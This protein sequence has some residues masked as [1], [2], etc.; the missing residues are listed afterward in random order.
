VGFSL[1]GDLAGS[2]EALRRG[3]ARSGT[4]P[5]PAVPSLGLDGVRCEPGPATAG[6]CQVGARRERRLKRVFRALTS[7][8]MLGLHLLAV[9]ATTAAVLL[10]LWQLHAWQAHRDLQAHDLAG[11]P[12]KPLVE[13][14][15]SDDPYP[16]DAV[17]Q[18]VS[19]T[20]E[21]LPRDTMF[22]ADR[23]LGGRT[24]FWV[25][26][27][28]AVCDSGCPDSPAM[29]VV[30]GWTGSPADAPDAPRGRVD[31]TGWLQPPDA[32]DAPDPDPA[33]DVLPALR[34]ADAIQRV[35]Q[36]LYGAYVIAQ[37]VSTS[38]GGMAG[39]EPVTP[40]SLPQP[41]TFT[42]IRNLLYALEWWVF[43]GFALFLWWR[44]CSDEV[45]QASEDR[46][47]E[48]ASSP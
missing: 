17:G 46:E 38:P 6:P 13:V 34:I 31:V 47:A 43:G 45:R 9:V 37:D 14:M 18:P 20:G 26:T 44:W 29:L 8:R 39:L 41:E 22:V 36:D 40:D 11:A 42:A 1:S 4:E 15:S 33:D 25:V 27:P 35:D 2:T 10:G 16:G 3:V 19:F 24:G 48:V 5:G 30:R 7:P 21:W 23:P 32:A 12:A 28:V